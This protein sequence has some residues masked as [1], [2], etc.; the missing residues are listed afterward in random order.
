MAGVSRPEPRP[1]LAGTAGL[2]ADSRPRARALPRSQL[3]QSGLLR[4]R[5]CSAS[6]HVAC[7]RVD[8]WHVE[9]RGVPVALARHPAF[10]PKALGCLPRPGGGP[11]HLRQGSEGTGPSPKSALVLSLLSTGSTTCRRMRSKRSAAPS[12][13]C[14]R[15]LSWGATPRWSVPSQPNSSSPR[16]ATRRASSVSSGA[17]RRCRPMSRSSPGGRTADARCGE[18]AMRMRQIN[19]ESY[20]ATGGSGTVGLLGGSHVRTCLSVGAAVPRFHPGARVTD[21][22]QTLRSDPWARSRMDALK[23]LMASPKRLLEAVGEYVADRVV[24]PVPIQSLAADSPRFLTHPPAAPPVAAPAVAIKRQSIAAPDSCR[25]KIPRV[26]LG[27]NLGY[28]SSKKASPGSKKKVSPLKTVKPEP[29]SKT[30][31]T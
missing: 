8:R 4:H 13:R 7:S 27:S 31:P 11:K 1:P 23:N 26:S 16:R 21:T 10:P 14:A 22:F 30:S 29:M 20:T 5:P 19:T 28:D 6:Q 3:L 18:R 15:P 17:A 12:P 24:G 25:V 9:Q 2:E